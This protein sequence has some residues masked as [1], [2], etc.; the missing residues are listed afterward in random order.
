MKIQKTAGTP[1]TRRNPAKGMG[2][3]RPQVSM[4]GC[5]Q[6][7][8]GSLLQP[9]PFPSLT[10]VMWDVL[11]RDSTSQATK[12]PK[13]FLVPSRLSYQKLQRTLHPGQKVVQEP[14]FGGYGRPVV[15]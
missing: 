12:C 8:H 5:T 15:P 2:K 7:R 1:L 11:H 3:P 10:S 9:L 6:R 4:S 14:L 13:V